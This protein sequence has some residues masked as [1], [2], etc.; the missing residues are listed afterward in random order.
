M[1]KLIMISIVTI[2][3]GFFLQKSSYYVSFS[4][5]NILIEIPTWSVL[6]ALIIFFSL[7]IRLL[8][9]VFHNNRSIKYAKRT[10]FYLMAGDPKL[11]EKYALKINTKSN[12]GFLGLLFATTAAKEQLAWERCNKYLFKAE[13]LAEEEASSSEVATF[14]IIKSELYYNQG[15][16]NKSL[17]ELKKLHKKFPSHKPLLLQLTSIYQT[18]N[19]W[20]ALIKLLPILKKYQIYN[21]FD[22]EQLEFMAYKN[23]LEQLTTTDDT[24]AVV[25]FFKNLPKFIKQNSQF[26]VIYVTCLIKLKHYDQAEKTIKIYLSDKLNNWNSNLIKLYGLIKSSNIKNQIK[27][28]EAWL[29]IHPLDDKL[30]LTLGRLCVQEDLLGK[31]K[32]YLEKSL[33]IKENPDCYAE[34]GRLAGLIGESEKSLICYQK[35]LLKTTELVEL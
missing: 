18:L 4:Y 32:N 24:D 27:T 29:V 9:S 26:V 11:A 12:F 7:Q 1:I 2:T 19:D 30:L 17:Y 5:N 8:K 13:I 20:Q 35:G 21:T 28:A 15:E 14:G 22:Y 23:H 10:F 6:A 31:A 3:I 33:N 16:Y 25:K 34:L